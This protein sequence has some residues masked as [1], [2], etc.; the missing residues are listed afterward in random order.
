M[1]IGQTGPK[2]TQFCIQY[3]P[4]IPTEKKGREEM[5]ISFDSKKKLILYKKIESKKTWGGQDFSS[6]RAKQS[7]QS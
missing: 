2:G 5:S 4:N 1:H 6:A 3:I 7:Q